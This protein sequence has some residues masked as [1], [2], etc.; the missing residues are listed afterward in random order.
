MHERERK[1]HGHAYLRSGDP[2]L[3]VDVGSASRVKSDRLDLGNRLVESAG[4][5]L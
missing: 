5:V 3:Y 1:T 2:R 4:T